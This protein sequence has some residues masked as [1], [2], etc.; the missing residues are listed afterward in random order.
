MA[1]ISRK[2]FIKGVGKTV[3]GVTVVGALGS[4]LSSCSA[5]ETT[6]KTADKPQWPFTYT[7]VDPEKAMERAFKAYKEKGG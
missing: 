4:V 7:K 1:E 3:A 6:A 5:S 2:E